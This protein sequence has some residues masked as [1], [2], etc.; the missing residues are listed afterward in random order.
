MSPSSRFGPDGNSGLQVL[1]ADG[2]RLFCREKRLTDGD[3]SSAL[4]V[5]P[6]LEW[7]WDCRSAAPS[8]MP[9][10]AGFGQRRTHP[11]AP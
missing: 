11:A 1:W 10:E 5:L 4:T 2:E 7:E 8:L 9:M 6:V 3:R